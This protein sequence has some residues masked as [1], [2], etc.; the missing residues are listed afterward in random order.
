[1]SICACLI[2]T[3]TPVP[4]RGVAL[5]ALQENYENYL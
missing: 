4:L 5:W 1:M 3:F 2:Y